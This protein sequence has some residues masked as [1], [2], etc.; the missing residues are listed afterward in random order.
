MAPPPPLR[1]LATAAAALL[2]GDIGPCHAFVSPRGPRRGPPSALPAPPSLGPTPPLASTTTLRAASNGSPD[3]PR[4]AAEDAVLQWDLFTRHHA[5]DGEWWGIW[6]TFDYMG[7]S[8]DKAAAGVCLTPSEKG[9]AVTHAHK[10]VAS[11]TQSD[12]A[13]CFSSS[14]VTTMPTI[15]TYTP[16][17]LGRRI[18]CAANGMVA[19][20]SVLRSGAMST[21]LVLRH[22]D[23][24]VRATFQHAPV[25]ERGV[26]PGSCPPQGLKLFRAVVAKEKL[27]PGENYEGVEGTIQGP[28]SPE[29]EKEDPPSP[30]N[31]RFFRP[32]PPFKWHAKWS[33]TSWTWGPQTGDRGWAISEVDE[34][35]AWHGRPA[36]DAAGTWSLR[37][38][39]GVLIQCPRVV[40]GGAA[41]LCR[42]AWMPEDDGEAGTPEDGNRAKL[43]RI[44]ASVSALEPVISDED[45]E[46]MVGF[47]PPSLGSLRTDVLEKVGEL[48]GATLE[49]REKAAA[50]YVWGEGSE[51]GEEEEAVAPMSEIGSEAKQEKAA[52]DEELKKKI[53]ADP[54]NA[55]DL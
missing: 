53:E 5:R 15:A 13:T 9:D 33:G 46:M 4:T 11:S 24:R 40:V 21:E 19:G 31:P 12:C 1:L 32:V 20:P 14:E 39:G 35:D 25:W 44:E 38:P 30:G 6:D 22:G 2:A 23:G 36:G 37:L 8:V 47:H 50:G 52:M 3:A 16:E 34:A 54:R 55:L 51:E 28:P 43:L 7:D 45:E 48:E 41:G 10:M 18:R 17:T 42:L 49:D 26:E 27:R 29:E